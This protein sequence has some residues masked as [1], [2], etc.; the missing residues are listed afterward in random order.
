MASVMM[1]MAGGWCSEPLC[2]R[3][4]CCGASH[5]TSSCRAKALQALFGIRMLVLPGEQLY[6]EPCF[7]LVGLLC[8]TS[9]GRPQGR[10]KVDSQCALQCNHRSWGD[11]FIDVLTTEGHAQMLSRLW[12]KG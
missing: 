10:L 8:S 2:W 7:Y 3:V 11:F 5:A 4:C 6:K 12:R 1:H 9:V